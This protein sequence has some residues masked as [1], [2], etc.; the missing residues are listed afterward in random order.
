MAASLGCLPRSLAGQ[1]GGAG[2]QLMNAFHCDQ[3]TATSGGT[4]VNAVAEALTDASRPRAHKSRDLRDR[5]ADVLA[6]LDIRPGQH[7]VDLL[8]F[9]GYF[10]RLFATLVG[11]RGHVYAAVPSDVTRIER[12]AKGKMELEELA[13]TRS[14]VSVISG[15]AQS[16]GGP[17]RGIDLFWLSNN[18]HDLEGPFMGP[19]D[20]GRFNAAVYRSL[21]RG[22]AYVIIDHAA[23]IGCP[24]DV[25]RRLHRI[26]PGLVRRQ[27][28]DAGF[29]LESTSAL[30]ANPEDPGTAGIFGRGI[31]YHTDRF[32]LKFRKPD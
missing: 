13:V 15:T 24:T 28:E 8:P 18:Y 2:S 20:M 7:V 6:L 12:I 30:L 17:P 31:R 11:P 26:N 27:V 32:I 10:T 29:V 23:K 25:A 21:K 22:A 1:T 4:G 16:A 9:R 14:N 19:L 5:T 3:P